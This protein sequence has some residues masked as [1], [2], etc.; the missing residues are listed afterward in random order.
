MNE[1]SPVDDLP[2]PPSGIASETYDSGNVE[3]YD[4]SEKKGPVE[5]QQ[6]LKEKLKQN[7]IT[8]KDYID[9]LKQNCQLIGFNPNTDKFRQCVL[10][11]M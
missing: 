3:S 7:D 9:S 1:I 8:D 5:A 2:I 4:A 6:K 11:L 10:E